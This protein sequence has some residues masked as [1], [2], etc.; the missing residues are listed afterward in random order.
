MGLSWERRHP[1]RENENWSAVLAAWGVE[2]RRQGCRRSQES[3][4]NPA[5]ADLIFLN[6]LCL[7]RRA[8]RETHGQCRQATQPEI[9]SPYQRAGLQRPGGKRTNQFLKD[10]LTLDSRQRCPE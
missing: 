1:C 3:V 9:R 4:T 8:A 6:G 2:T 10:D 5:Y 7:S